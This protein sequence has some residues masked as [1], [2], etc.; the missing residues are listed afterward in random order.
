VTF[1]AQ[2]FELG[3]HQEPQ[4][5]VDGRQVGDL[6]RRKRNAREMVALLRSSGFIV[7]LLT[8]TGASLV[9]VVITRGTTRSIA[10]AIAVGVAAFSGLAAEDV[11]PGALVVAVF[12]LA[13]GALVA[14]SRSFT[15]RAAAVAPG[16]VV[17]VTV[18][19]PD[20]PGW[21]RGLVFVAVLVASPAGEIVDYRVPSLIFAFIAL[22]SLGVYATVPDTEQA[23]TLVGALLPVAAAAVVWRRLSES[24]GPSVSVALVVW[25]GLVGGVGRPGSVVGAIGC[26]GVLALGPLARLSSPI[27]LIVVQLGVVALASRVVG[28]RQ[29]AWAAVAIAV[30]IM[31]VAAVVLLAGQHGRMPDPP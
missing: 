1:V 22:S 8:A 15:V 30:P 14:R 26:L 19:A 21:A 3:E 17:L 24:V 2:R 12:L 28:F 6:H 13:A 7:A 20:T 31:V 4:A 27:R 23:R 10:L 18:S 16:A 25:G 9:A 5:Q 11:L 29:S